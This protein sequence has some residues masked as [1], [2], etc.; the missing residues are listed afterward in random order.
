M[1]GLGLGLLCAAIE[2]LKLRGVTSCFVD[3]VSSDF[4]SILLTFLDIA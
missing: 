4:E 2:Q 3:W 1:P